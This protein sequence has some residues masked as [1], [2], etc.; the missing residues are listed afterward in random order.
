[1]LQS[2]FPAEGKMVDGEKLGSLLPLVNSSFLCYVC[3]SFYLAKVNRIMNFVVVSEPAVQQISSLANFT[4]VRGHVSSIKGVG[5]ISF[6]MGIDWE[7]SEKVRGKGSVT[8]SWY[9]R[10]CFEFYY[11]IRS[12]KLKELFYRVK[13][14]TVYTRDENYFRL[15]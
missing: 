6:T 1:M 11:Y 15:N 9:T 14:Q 3:W 12:L 13:C 4:G 5:Q 7:E 2:N 10:G 8:H